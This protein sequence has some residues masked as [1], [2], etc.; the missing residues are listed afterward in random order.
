MVPS[1]RRSAFL[2]AIALCVLLAGCVST[3]GPSGFP[4]PNPDGSPTPIPSD[5]PASTPDGAPTPTSPASYHA[6]TTPVPLADSVSCSDELYVSPWGIREFWRPD[7]VMYG[8]YLPPNSS[9]VFVAYVDG[10][11]AGVDSV[12]NEMTDDGVNIDGGEITLDESLS[13]RHTVRIVAYSDVNRN[14]AFDAGTDRPCATDDGLV[15]TT[16]YSVDFSRL[17]PDT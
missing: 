11:I 5:S 9:Y 6:T 13:G 4:T 16:L 17:T 2:C 12:S 8:T 3:G 10:S 1:P 15:Q 7:A 14:G